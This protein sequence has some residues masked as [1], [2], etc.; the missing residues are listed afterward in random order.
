MGRS[1]RGLTSTAALAA[2]NTPFSK[3]PD[4]TNIKY[5][6]MRCKCDR[7]FV[8][9]DH[10]D[11]PDGHDGCRA[12]GMR[13]TNPDCPWWEGQSPTALE[14]EVFFDA[15]IVELPARAGPMLKAG[16]RLRWQRVRES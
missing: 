9:E 14:P 4:R 11:R 13:C 6:N 8:C 7:G 15:P 3:L 2:T 16:T 12:A 10:P 5:L 1:P